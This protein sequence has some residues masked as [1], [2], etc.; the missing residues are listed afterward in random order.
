M[1]STFLLLSYSFKMENNLAALLLNLQFISCRYSAQY[2]YQ[3]SEISYSAV[4][5]N[6]NCTSTNGP[7]IQKDSHTENK[8]V[9]EELN[10]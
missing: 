9:A 7:P 1:I 6:F 10:L 3:K 8:A 4:S 2:G 5:I